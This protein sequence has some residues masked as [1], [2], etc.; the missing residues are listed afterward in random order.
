MKTIY[1]MVLRIFFPVLLAAIFFFVLMLELGDLFPNVTA[2]IDKEVPVGVVARILLFYA[3]KCVSYALPVGLVFSVSFTL[4][5]LYK[6]NELIAIFGSGISLARLV[7]PF[8][9]IGFALSAGA[10]LFEE[11]VVIETLEKKNEL[12]KTAVRRST[13]LSNANVTVI[14]ADGRSVYQA[15]FYDDG[16]AILRELIVLRRIMDTRD[17]ER[18]D[19][20]WAEWVDDAWVLHDCIVYAWSGE[21]FTWERRQQVGSEEAL[22]EPP[23]SFQKPNRALEELSIRE[24]REW[25]ERLKRGGLP[26]LES[27]TE[28]YRRF[29]YAGTPFIVCVIAASVGGRFRKNILLMNLLF[30]LVLTVVY[31]VT[32]MIT[33]ILAK[34]GIIPPLL[35]AGGATIVLLVIGIGAMRSARS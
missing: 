5:N 30:S 3:P 35:G 19:A 33:V 17:Y 26:Y 12:H 18:F 23:W 7:A 20:A 9:A 13:S 2:Y 4:G 28:Y 21:G 11:R 1:A 22:R 14:S 29:F 27:Q 10:F 6:N 25:V 32:Q 31:Y 24:A 34:N 15:D 8:L 16:K